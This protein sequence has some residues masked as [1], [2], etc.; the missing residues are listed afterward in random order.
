MEVNPFVSTTD[1]GLLALA[2][3]HPDFLPFGVAPTHLASVVFCAVK[4]LIFNEKRMTAEEMMEALADN[5]LD[6]PAARKMML[7]APKYGV[8]HEEADAFFVELQDFFNETAKAQANR[9]G[10][11]S[12]L[13]VYI[14]NSLVR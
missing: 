14:N 4:K 8:D 5:F 11:K 13:P 10:L 9:V 3:A 1:S 12:Y 6:Y 7:E 2:V